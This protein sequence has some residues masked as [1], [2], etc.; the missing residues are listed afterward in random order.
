MEIGYNLSGEEHSPNDLVKNAQRAEELGFDF[1]L[2]SDHYH[3]WLDRQGHSV[4][5]WSVIGGIAHTTQRL[6][7][8]TGVTCPI[9]RIHPAI[10]AQ[11][12]ATCAAMMPGRFFLGI[13]TGENLNEHIL[14]DHWPPAPVRLDMLEEA[15]EIIRELWKG[16]EISHEGNY[17]IVEN[18]RIYTLPEE[19]PPIYMAASGEMASQLAGRLCDGLI[20]TS[21]DES[22]LQNFDEGGGKGKPRY[23]KADVCWAATEE[24]ALKIAYEWWTNAGIKGQLAQELATP[25]LMEQAASMVRE[26]D[27]AKSMVLGS[28]PEQH[29]AQIRKYAEAGFDHIYIHNIGPDQEGFFQFYEKEILPQWN[30]EFA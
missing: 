10:I 23:G 7:L 6:R 30:K 15:V 5:V 21:A 8:G 2:I 25:A 18:A 22:V 28:D 11:A 14:G 26:E 19:L 24:E 9:M 12:A 27:V 4:F 1:A 13:G 3:P 17:F 20:A 29:F 16:E